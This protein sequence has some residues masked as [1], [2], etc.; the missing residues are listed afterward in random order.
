[1]SAQDWPDGYERDEEPS[2]RP[3]VEA[4][5]PVRSGF[6]PGPAVALVAVVAVLA[7]VAV[8]VITLT[9]RR[10]PTAAPTPP[11]ATKVSVEG[12]GAP[13]NVRLTDHGASVTL[14]WTDPSHG[15]AAFLVTGTGPDNQQLQVR[16]VP[17]GQ[18]TAVYDGLSP[19]ARYCF[20]V[21]ALYT[22]SRLS[23]SPAVCTIR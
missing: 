18:T 8:A 6:R 9:S 3:F 2:Y 4:D 14:T 15:T 5:G 13:T 1:V 11:S 21:S 23:P 20:K 17:Q 16:Q 12:S 7:L 19:T 22:F 10:S